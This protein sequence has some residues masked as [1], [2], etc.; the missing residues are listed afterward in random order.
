MLLDDNVSPSQLEIDEYRDRKLAS[1]LRSK[2]SLLIL[3]G[4]AIASVSLV[5]NTLDVSEWDDEEPSLV[6]FELVKHA[7]PS[8]AAMSA[9]AVLEDFQVY[10]PVLTPSGATDETVLGNGS[11]NTTIIGQTA[12]VSSCEVLLM[13]H[14]FGYSYGIPFVGK[15]LPL[16]YCHSC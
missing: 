9:A 5:W 7:V 8:S 6:L 10:Q 15:S 16:R 3:L 14:S 13:E 2:L 1:S 11:E 4:L 12:S